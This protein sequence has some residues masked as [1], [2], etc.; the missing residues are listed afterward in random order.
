MRFAERVMKK[1]VAA[2]KYV[3]KTKIPSHSDDL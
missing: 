3:K 1:Q 2:L